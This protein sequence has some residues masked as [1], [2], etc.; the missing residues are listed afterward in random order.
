MIVI[1]QKKKGVHLLA[2]F[3]PHLVLQLTWNHS[4]QLLPSLVYKHSSVSHTYKNTISEWT[5]W[6]C[7]LFLISMCDTNPDSCTANR[8]NKIRFFS[9]MVFSITLLS[10]LSYWSEK[11]HFWRHILT[12]PCLN[13]FSLDRS[14]VK[15]MLIRLVP[16]YYVLRHDKN[17]RNVPI[18]ML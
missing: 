10:L 13:L 15:L 9:W 4:Q 16:L 2:V 6:V 5:N 1:Y 11:C 8:D 17:T 7:E 12:H 3:W 14:L 18:W